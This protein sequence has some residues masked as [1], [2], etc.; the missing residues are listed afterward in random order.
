MFVLPQLKRVRVRC[1]GMPALAQRDDLE[2]RLE[3]QPAWLQSQGLPDY[4]SSIGDVQFDR[5]KGEFTAVVEQ[6]VEARLWVGLRD[7]ST[8]L[9][10]EPVTLS[11]DVAEVTVTISEATRAALAPF[12]RR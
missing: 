5:E 7:A 8:P 12:A 4:A 1:V 6:A 9:A 2:V 10:T 3:A 11:P